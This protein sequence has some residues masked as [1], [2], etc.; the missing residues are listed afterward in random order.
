MM[1]VTLYRRGHYRPSPRAI[2]KLTR[3]LAASAALGVLLALAS[4]FR[5]SIQAVFAPLSIGPLHAKEWAICVVVVL[6]AA[7]YPL[8]LFASGGLTLAETK[9]AL[10][11]KRGSPPEGPADLP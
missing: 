11:R 8:L 1:A 2:F 10:R 6:A 7:T 5:T 4:H 3:I 9:A